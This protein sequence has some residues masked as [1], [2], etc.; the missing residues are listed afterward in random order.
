MFQ[1]FPAKLWTKFSTDYKVD[2]RSR[3]LWLA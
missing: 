2:V 1:I 3:K